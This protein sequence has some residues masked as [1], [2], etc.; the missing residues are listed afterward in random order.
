MSQ[1]RCQLG[2][3]SQHGSPWILQSSL[4]QKNHLTSTGQEGDRT[5]VQFLGGKGSCLLQLLQACAFKVSRLVAT[6]LSKGKAGSYIPMLWV[7]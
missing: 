3:R 6:F 4:G 7:P 2:C 1:K 5:A